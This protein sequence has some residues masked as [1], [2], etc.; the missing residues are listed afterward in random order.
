MHAEH[1][2]SVRRRSLVF[3]RKVNIL[4]CTKRC[5]G[6]SESALII[7]VNKTGVRVQ[8]CLD[9]YIFLNDI[10]EKGTLNDAQTGIIILN[11]IALKSFKHA[12]T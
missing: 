4:I 1:L 3:T 8:A 7:R 10:A 11:D 5:G 9:V 2:T 6:Y 12:R